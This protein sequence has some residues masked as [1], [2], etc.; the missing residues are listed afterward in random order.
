[1]K[2]FISCFYPLSILYFF[3][4]NIC[5]K[6]SQLLFSILNNYSIYKLFTVTLTHTLTDTRMD[7]YP[8]LWCIVDAGK[9]NDLSEPMRR[10]GKATLLPQ[11]HSP[12]TISNT[13]S[14]FPLCRTPC[15]ACRGLTSSMVTIYSSTVLR[16]HR[17]KESSHSC[18]F[19]CRLKLRK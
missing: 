13:A 7:T 15:Q 9:G 8:Y 19:G 12:T 11:A 2:K 3:L 10:K 17:Q 1:M 18:H 4:I 5:Q 16:K 14:S 6:T